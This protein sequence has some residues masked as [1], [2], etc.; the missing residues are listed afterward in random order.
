MYES[1]SASNFFDLYAIDIS[2]DDGFL[3]FTHAHTFT[4]TYTL[5]HIDVSID[6]GS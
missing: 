1:T 5:T 6:F 2:R 4:H 3:V